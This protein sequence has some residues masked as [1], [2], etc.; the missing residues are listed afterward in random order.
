MTKLPSTKDSYSRTRQDHSTETAEDYVEAIYEIIE[1]KGACRAVDLAEQFGVSHVTV[2]KIVSRLD[3]DGLVEAPAY[4]PIALTT[5]G[6]SMAA[7]VRKRH[8]L[9]YSFLI[10]IGVDAKNAAIDSEG[11]EHHVSSKTLARMRAFVEERN[12]EPSC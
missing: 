1:A 2:S 10:A 6:K 9:V 12:G 3:T 11:I 4:R 8:E 7:R 5:E